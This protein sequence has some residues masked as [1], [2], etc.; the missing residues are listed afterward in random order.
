MNNHLIILGIVVLLICVGLSGCNEIIN[1]NPD[2]VKFIGSW[3]GTGMSY[4]N[5]YTFEE[6][7]TLIWQSIVAGTWSVKDGGRLELYASGSG[8]SGT[9]VYNYIFSDNDNTL[10]LT[11]PGSTISE[12]YNKQ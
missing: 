7:G 12:I 3:Q 1:N 6:D 4:L 5:L 8:G 11:P 9:L 2:R 10:T